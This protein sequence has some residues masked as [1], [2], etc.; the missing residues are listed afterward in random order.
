[1]QEPSGEAVAGQ[2]TAEFLF[3][4]IWDT[5]AD[6]LGEAATAALLRRSAKRALARLPELSALQIRRDGFAY[7]Y[8]VPQSWSEPGGERTTAV[9][10]LARELYPLLVEMTGEVVVRRLARIQGLENITSSGSEASK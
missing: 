8:E 4:Q 10:D 2:E 9:Q 6:V 3:G 1:V 7:R 5:L